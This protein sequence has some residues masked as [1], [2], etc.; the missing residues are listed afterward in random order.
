[1]YWIP[2]VHDFLACINLVLCYIRVYIFCGVWLE[3]S[4]HLY[5]E[6]LLHLIEGQRSI[7]SFVVYARL[8]RGGVDT[9]TLYHTLQVTLV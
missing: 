9:P 5:I 2:G 7:T 3:L 4:T 8:I 6:D 1:M